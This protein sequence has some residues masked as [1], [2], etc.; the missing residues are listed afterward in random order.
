MYGC[1][2]LFDAVTADK[3]RTEVRAQ[4]GGVCPCDVDKK[5]PLLPDP[6]IPLKDLAATML[7]AV[8]NL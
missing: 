7:P 1:E 6:V 2:I 4:M 8:A 3:V 5:C